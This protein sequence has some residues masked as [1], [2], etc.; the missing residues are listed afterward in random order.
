MTR[1]TAGLLKEMITKEIKEAQKKELQK[2]LCRKLGYG[3]WAD[4]LKRMNAWE[5]AQKGKLFEPKKKNEEQSRTERMDG[6]FDGWKEFQQMSKGIVEEDESELDEKKAKKK[7]PRYKGCHGNPFHHPE[8]GE[9]MTDDELDASKKGSASFWYACQNKLGR[10][11][12]RGRKHRFIKQP[13]KCGRSST[14][15]PRKKCSDG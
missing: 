9:F 2:R 10:V 12:T 4:F 1:L 5:K 8:T 6:L 13:D 11:A 14:T 15:N 7:E 3:T